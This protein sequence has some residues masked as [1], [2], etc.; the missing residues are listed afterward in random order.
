METKNIVDWIKS[1]KIKVRKALEGSF[2][3]V[4]T[5]TNENETIFTDYRGKR[6]HIYVRVDL[7][8]DIVT[9]LERQAAEVEMVDLQERMKELQT[10]LN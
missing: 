8:E 3:V 2:E 9:Q 6:P 7:P 10:K 4:N 1:N 5:E